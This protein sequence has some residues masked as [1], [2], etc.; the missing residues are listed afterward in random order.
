MLLDKAYYYKLQRDALK[1]KVKFLRK[2]LRA[3]RV[4]INR[5]KE[6]KNYYAEKF[7][8]KMSFK[9]DLTFKESAIYTPCQPKA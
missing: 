9:F 6:Q 3:G 4:R 5:Y 1:G 7:Q 8:K 2:Q